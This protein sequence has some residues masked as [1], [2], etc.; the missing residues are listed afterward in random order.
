MFQYQE[1]AFTI[2]GRRNKQIDTRIGKANVFLRELYCSVVI[3]R[4]LSNTVKLSIFKSVFAPILTY[5]HESWVMAERM[6][7]QLQ[8]A[9]IWFLP[10]VHGVTLLRQSA[11][12]WNSQSPECRITSHPNREIPATL[13][14]PCDQR[15][16]GKIAEAC[17]AGYT[18]GKA[19]QRSSKDQVA[20]LRLRNCLV[21]SWCGAIRT[22]RD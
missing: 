13:V 1:V 4:K 10:R 8:A 12:L 7:P 14:W 16:P 19:S 6:L 17:P 21:L 3:K 9:E 2:D 15:V 11:Q 22:T 18:H 20:W 5:V